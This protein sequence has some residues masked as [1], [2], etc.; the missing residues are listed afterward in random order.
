MGIMA[1][2]HR[3][4]S[5]TASAE[6]VETIFRCFSVQNKAQ[7]EALAA[8]FAAETNAVQNN[9][10]VEIRKVLMK[11]HAYIHDRYSMV[12]FRIT[13]TEGRPVT[14]FDLLLTAG[15][16]SNPD[17]LPEGFFADRQCNKL[18]KNTL[19]Y[20]FN[21]DIMLGTPAVPDPGGS[22]KPLREKTDG[23]QMLGLQLR[24]R[25]DK[26]FVQYVP[27]RIDASREMLLKAIHP[28]GTTLIDICVQRVV[29]KE[30]FRFVQV[31]G[32][33]MP[34]FDFKGTKPGG[35]AVED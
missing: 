22:K 24:L 16:D 3:E 23:A 27:C 28:N 13:D 17:H 29:D 6:T 25:P 30:V 14:D 10:K 12:I 26:G 34:V 19:T 9:E 20:F 2:V 18:N 35:Y 4:L 1:S 33:D 11:D 32:S 21:Y 5:D 8:A 7:Y 15:P 31:T